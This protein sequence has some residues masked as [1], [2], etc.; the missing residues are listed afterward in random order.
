MMTAAD[1]V[2]YLL[3]RGLL[4]AQLV[5]DGDVVVLDVSR[6]NRNY[7]VITRAASSFL[8]KQS[9]DS[10]SSATIEREA[11]VYQWLHAQAGAPVVRY[12]PRFVDFDPGERLLVLE[13]LPG[14][15]TYRE[16]QLHG[17]RFPARPIGI[18]GSALAELHR[19]WRPADFPRALVSSVPWILSIHRPQIALLQELSAANHELIKMAQLY[20]D[21]G[22]QL[23]RLRAEWIGDA[24][25]HGDLKWDN[26]IA[27]GRGVGTT[28]RFVDWELGGIGDSA[29]DVGCVFADYLS[30]WLLSIPITGAEPPDQVTGLARYPLELMQPAIRRFWQSYA[31]RLQLEPPTAD[32]LLVRAVRYSGARLLQTAFEHTQFAVQVTGNVVCLMQLSVNILARPAEACIHLLGLPLRLVAA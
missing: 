25:I 3:G 6:R 20:P 32:E 22:E 31:G 17:R 30:C 10:R 5:V 29:W 1:V 15:R 28:L 23:D 19:S 2:P 7:K 4:S 13:L 11:M 14:A 16:Q 18:L 12:I 9:S 27:P 8:L 21:F 24:F 26:C